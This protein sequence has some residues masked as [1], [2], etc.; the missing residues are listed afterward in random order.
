MSQRGRDRKLTR[1]CHDTATELVK[2][3]VKKHTTIPERRGMLLTP[4]MKR[5]DFGAVLQLF[6]GKRTLLQDDSDPEPR[7]L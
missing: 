5:R 6:E 4:F 3:A 7:K 2:C 1:L